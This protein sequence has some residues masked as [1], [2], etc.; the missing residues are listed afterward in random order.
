[1][2]QRWDPRRSIGYLLKDAQALL[3]AEMDRL[4]RPL[5]LTVPQYACMTALARG[6]DQSSADL[7]RAS[8][9]SRQSMNVLLAGMERNGWVEPVPDPAPGRARPYRLT[10]AGAAL[11]EPADDAV[12]TLEEAMVGQLDEEQ[13]DELRTLLA[14]CIRGLQQR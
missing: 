11:L 2:S 8:F 14:A 4:L 7:A 1:M 9:V 5:G 6:V 10:S 13:R 3:R 12:L